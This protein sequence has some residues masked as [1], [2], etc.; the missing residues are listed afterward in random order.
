MLSERPAH[1]D[2][3]GSLHYTQKPPV[4]RVHIAAAVVVIYAVKNVCIDLIK[5]GLIEIVTEMQPKR[6]AL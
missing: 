6:L 3:G 4:L 2:C 1:F 5:D